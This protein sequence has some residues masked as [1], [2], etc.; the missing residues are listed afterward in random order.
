MGWF[1]SDSAPATRVAPHAVMSK[2]ANLLPPPSC[3]MHQASADAMKPSVASSE[4]ACPYTPRNSSSIPNEHPQT[5][6][7]FSKLNPLNYM[8]KELSQERAPTQK[9][10]LETERETS[11]IP[12]G[13][14]EGTW[15]YPSPQQMYNA[16]LR[17]GYT[18]TDAEAVPAMVS[19]HNSLNELA[20]REIMIHEG[21][22]SQGLSNGWKL[23]QR[24]EE[25]IQAVADAADPKLLRFKGRP[26]DMT[27]KA[28]MVQIMSWIYP[29]GFGADPPF[30]RHDWTVERKVGGQTKEIRYVIDYYAGPDELNG[31]P[32][33]YLDVRPAVDSPTLALER[34][35][36]WGG[37]VWRRGSGLSV[38][39][40]SAA[41]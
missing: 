26:K 18:D 14:G 22:F 33:F 35:A 4:S 8:F 30:D 24:N 37:D 17:K 5:S 2:E 28:T 10:A 16:L 31:D 34:M 1:W 40:A 29:T 11:T 27:P 38:R 15:E 21:L 19:L 20:W 13:S 32:T 9:V 7:T 3:P 36:R 41:K 39:E 25:E 23:A 12:K 6:S